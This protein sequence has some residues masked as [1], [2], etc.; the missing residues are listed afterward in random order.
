MLPSRSKTE[1]PRT[2]PRM[3]ISMSLHLPSRNRRKHPAKS[4][5]PSQRHM[6][7]MRRSRTRRRHRRRRRSE[8][9][10]V[11]RRR[12]RRQQQQRR[13]SRLSV[14]PAGPEDGHGRTPKEVQTFQRTRTGGESYGRTSSGVDAI[15]VLFSDC[16]DFP[17]RSFL[18]P[19]NHHNTSCLQLRYFASKKFRRK[20]EKGTAPRDNVFLSPNCTPQSVV[21]PIPLRLVVFGPVAKSFTNLEE[22]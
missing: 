16:S 21:L 1:T 17:V 9:V 12:G 18:P 19:T 3:G 11:H 2:S 8:V 6:T 4:D 10:D 20:R 5:R 15:F 13:E 14:V 7:M 22:E